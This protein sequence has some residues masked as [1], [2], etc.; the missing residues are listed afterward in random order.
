M[1]VRPRAAEITP[2]RLAVYYTVA[3]VWFFPLLW[4]ISKTFTPAADILGKAR[5][6]FPTTPTLEN[7]QAVW[8]NWP[9]ATWLVNSF[10]VTVCAVAI[11]L[12]VALFAGFSFARLRWPGRDIVF[13]MFLAGMFIPWEVNAIPLY[14][15]MNK[16]GLLNTYPGLFLPMT[17]MPVGLFLLRQFFINIPKE[18]EEAARVDGCGSLGVLLRILVPMTLPALGALAIFVFL[19]SWNEFFWSLICLQGSKRLTVP[20]GLK[21]IMGAQNIEYGLLF[22]ASFLAMMPSLV[23]FLLLR[24]QIIR[25]ISITGMIK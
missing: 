2:L 19:F 17:A 3:L 23:V 21:M 9:F 20:I 4:M 10:I 11:S 18:V 6:F 5:Q 8:N 14:F 13:L 16:F 24:R 15:I 12:V 25:G 7:L 22:G 1:S